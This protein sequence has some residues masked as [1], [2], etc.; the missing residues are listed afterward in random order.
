M[1]GQGR[2][3]QGRDGPMRSGGSGL[4]WLSLW[5][6]G[7]SMTAGCSSREL[8]G[9]R[10]PSRSVPGV[11]CGPDQ[12]RMQLWME[13][14]GRREDGKRCPALLR[15]VVTTGVAEARLERGRDQPPA[16]QPITITG[17]EP[18]TKVLPRCEMGRGSQGWNFRL[19][20]ADG[21]QTQVHLSEGPWRGSPDFMDYFLTFLIQRFLAEGA[22]RAIDQESGKECADV[23][24]SIE[25]VADAIRSK[26]PKPP[27]PPHLPQ[28]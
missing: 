3:A 24:E 20:L 9:L 14:L 4:T 22:D 16:G 8:H 2:Q 25:R 7:L 10:R 13:G 21:S 23:A 6:V 19:W 5:L 1:H 27:K 26:L 15:W 28:P 12:G 11:L 17:L 18:V